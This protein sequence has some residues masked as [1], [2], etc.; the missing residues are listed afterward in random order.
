M[1]RWEPLVGGL[2]C[3]ARGIGGLEIH[4]A[5]KSEKFTEKSKISQK[6]SNKN[7]PRNPKI[8]EMVLPISRRFVVSTPGIG[9]LEIQQENKF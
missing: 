1:R 4:Q 6:K 7:S 8:E 5:E 3:P 2:L 9:G